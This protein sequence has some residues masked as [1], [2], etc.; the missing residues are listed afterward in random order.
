[1]MGSL[2]SVVAAATAGARGNGSEGGGQEGSGRLG[3][4]EDGGHWITVVMV[5]LLLGSNAQRVL[6]NAACP[7]LAVRAEG[8]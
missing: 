8:H 3:I 7:V 5:K 6:L 2:E 1:M 4:S